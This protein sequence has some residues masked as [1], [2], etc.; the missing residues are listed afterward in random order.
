MVRKGGLELPPFFLSTTSSLPV[1][2]EDVVLGGAGADQRMITFSYTTGR[3]PRRW[4]G[5]GGG[6]RVGAGSS[7]WARRAGPEVQTGN[8]VD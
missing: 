7:R 3:G 5:G 4:A 2:G 1:T 8:Y 6:F